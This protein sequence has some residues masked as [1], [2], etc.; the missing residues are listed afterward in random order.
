MFDAFIA[1]AQAR[2]RECGQ[3]DHDEE[4]DLPEIPRFVFSI[5]SAIA[6]KGLAYCRSILKFSWEEFLHLCPITEPLLKPTGRGRSPKSD[7]INR[8]VVFLLY[9]TSEFQYRVI[10]ISLSCPVAWVQRIVATCLTRLASCFDCFI[11]K[12]AQGI[13]C[14]LTLESFPQ[15]FGIVYASPVFISRPRGDQAQFYSGKFK[16]HCVKVH[17]FVVSDGQCIHFE[18]VFKGSTHDKAIFE[19]PAVVG[20]ITYRDGDRER[21]HAIIMDLGYVGITR[22]SHIAILPHERAPHGQLTDAQAVRNQAV[23]R[24]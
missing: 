9:L 11:A 7:S 22:T 2:E 14:A 10:A 18:Q 3:G 23:G 15:V 12:T 4:K 17:A 5:R 8:F 24:D 1:A 19:R 20:F 21:Q 6:S 13:R 16:H